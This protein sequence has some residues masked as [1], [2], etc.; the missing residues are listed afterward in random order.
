MHSSCRTSALGRITQGSHIAYY[1]LMFIIAYPLNGQLYVFAG[2][3][4]IVSHS[5]CRISAIL[6]YFCPLICIH[7]LDI[8][9]SQEDVE[10][11]MKKEDENAESVLKKLDEQHN[12]YKFMEYNLTTKK[13]RWDNTFSWTPLNAF[14]RNNKTFFLAWELMDQPLIY[15]LNTLDFQQKS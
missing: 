7:S 13:A 15:N 10:S 6:R 1:S 4:K 8:F 9:L 14:V 2:R 11:F 3:V 5:S 12:K